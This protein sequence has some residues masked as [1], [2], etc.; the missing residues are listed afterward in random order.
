MKSD[1]FDAIVTCVTSEEE[2]FFREIG[3][4]FTLTNQIFDYFQKLALNF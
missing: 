3:R 4:N 2:V 1:R